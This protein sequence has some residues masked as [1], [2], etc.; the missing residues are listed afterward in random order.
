MAGR[1]RLKKEGRPRTPLCSACMS[2]PGLGMSVAQQLARGIPRALPVFKGCFTID[3]DRSVA[4]GPLDSAPFAAWEVM[5]DL[6]DP[7][8]VNIK[9]ITIPILALHHT[10]S[11]SIGKTIY[12]LI[13]ATGLASK[14]W[15]RRLSEKDHRR[16]RQQH[17]QLFVF[18]AASL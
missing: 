7:V 17:F 2:E 9:S 18:A 1:E 3:N 15:Q 4:F 5:C 11:G 8:W 14:P 16:M 12:A 10:A 6:S 13:A